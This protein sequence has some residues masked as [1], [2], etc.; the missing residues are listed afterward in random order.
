[1]LV[2]AASRPHQHLPTT[3]LVSC[4][5]GRISSK[6]VT[7]ELS[8]RVVAAVC[9]GRGM[10]LCWHASVL[11]QSCGRDEH[12]GC[13]AAALQLVGCGAQQPG[14]RRCCG[15]LYY[16]CLQAQAAVVGG[17]RPHTTPYSCTQSF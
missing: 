16:C 6:P 5:G 15:G 4:L 8:V 2:C 3:S 7:T 17:C 13:N 10:S 9:G 1:V 12:V 11:L 14:W